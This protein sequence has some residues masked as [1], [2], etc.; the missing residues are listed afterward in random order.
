MAMALDEWPDEAVDYI[1]GK[2]ASLMA[3]A[4]FYY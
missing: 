3:Y 1:L 4:L 2:G